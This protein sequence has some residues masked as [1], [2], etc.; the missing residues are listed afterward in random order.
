MTP[1]PEVESDYTLAETADKLRVSTRW[2]RDRIKAGSDPESGKP[3]VEHIRRGHKIMFTAAQVEKLRMADAETPPVEQSIT[4]GR[5]K[6]A[7]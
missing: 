6:R 1:T 4:T 2:I 3:F 7:S 5:K